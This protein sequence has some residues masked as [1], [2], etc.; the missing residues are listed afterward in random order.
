[1]VV[2]DLSRGAARAEC[3]HREALAE[4]EVVRCPKAGV[5]VSDAGGE[6][7]EH[8]TEVRHRLRL[9]NREPV[10]RTVAEPVEHR[11][12]E[13]GEPLRRVTIRPAAA[14]LCGTRHLPHV[15]DRSGCDSGRAEL[16][17]QRVVE[18]ERLRIRRAVAVR[19]DP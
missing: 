10:R 7:A 8:V 14:I 19:H 16:V 15:Q 5:D 11:R 3:L 2:A 17:H 4:Q 13:V 12:R 6:L 1:V 18:V 9:A